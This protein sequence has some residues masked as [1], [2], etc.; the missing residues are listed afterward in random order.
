MVGAAG[1]QVF[2]LPADEETARFDDGW[3]GIG[4]SVSDRA[5]ELVREIKKRLQRRSMCE[6]FLAPIG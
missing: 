5:R 2:G 4:G 3:L 6:L 1:C